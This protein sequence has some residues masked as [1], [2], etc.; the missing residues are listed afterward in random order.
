MSEILGTFKR[1]D[2][3]T[4]SEWELL[5]ECL[6]ENASLARFASF[7][8]DED[9]PNQVKPHLQSELVRARRQKQQALYECKLIDEHLRH[10]GVKP[11]FLKGAAYSVSDSAVGLGRLYGD[12]D[13]LVDKSD[14][15]KSKQ[16]LLERGWFPQILTDYDEMYYREWA[17]EIPPLTHVKRGTVLDLHHNLVPI[18]SGQAPDVADFSKDL[19]ETKDGLLVFSQAAQ[20]LHSA[21][22]LFLNEDFSHGIRDLT[23][24]HILFTS[25]KDDENYWE[26]LITL[27]SKSSFEKELQLA[28]RYCQK[29]LN[30]DI[31]SC[32]VEAIYALKETNFGLLDRCFESVLRFRH[33]KLDSTL[34]STYEL[35]VYMRGHFLKMP[36]SILAKHLTIKAWRSVVESTLGKNFY[37]KEHEVNR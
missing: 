2:D 26:S 17:H 11:I 30:T 3:L 12:I 21:V 22:H 18:V 13:V 31:Q 32:H 20:T 33:P 7:L 23:D 27:S 5:I 37:D 19:V 36:F 14:I 24:L 1:V 28:V 16:A 6:R 4:L 34:R 8:K 15:E 10:V 9:I 35:A 29:I 25:N